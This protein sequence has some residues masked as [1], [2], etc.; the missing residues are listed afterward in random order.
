MWSRLKEKKEWD[1]RDEWY[2]Y[3]IEW[4]YYVREKEN[5]KK[6]VCHQNSAK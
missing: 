3:I 6:W 1:A 4:L 2:K 5:K